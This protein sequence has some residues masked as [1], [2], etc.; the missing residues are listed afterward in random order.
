MSQQHVEY[1]SRREQAERKAAAVA[2]STA[3]RGCHSR[4][5]DFHAAKAIEWLQGTAVMNKA[6]A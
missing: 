1:H 3:A 5:A 6:S 2:A 4:L